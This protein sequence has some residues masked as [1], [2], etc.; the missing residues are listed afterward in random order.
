MSDLTNQVLYRFYFDLGRELQRV[1]ISKNL[2]MDEVFKKRGF[3]KVKTLRRMEAG[4]FYPIFYYMQM[5][6]FY[7]QRLVVHLEDEL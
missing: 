7:K 1:R 2:S 5:I 6:H 3:R 4:K